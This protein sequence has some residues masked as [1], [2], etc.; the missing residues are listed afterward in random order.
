MK[1][2]NRLHEHGS[3]WTINQKVHQ[4]SLFPIGPS[5]RHNWTFIF[6]PFH[7]MIFHQI[8]CE[9]Q[10]FLKVSNSY[11]MKSWSLHTHTILANNLNYWLEN[12]IC[13]YI[14][15]N[16]SLLHPPC[17]KHT[18]SFSYFF[19]VGIIDGSLIHLSTHSILNNH[20]CIRN[21]KMIHR[22]FLSWFF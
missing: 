21:E 19:F 3:L 16:S 8:F 5:I 18:S 13:D 15:W 2:I 10:F 17:D 1:N 6:S 4:S 22:T 20:F 9:S 14:K 12:R 7:H 11:L